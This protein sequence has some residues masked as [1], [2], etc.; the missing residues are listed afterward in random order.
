MNPTHEGRDPLPD[1]DQAQA[2]L[3]QVRARATYDPRSRGDATPTW[4][5]YLLGPGWQVRQVPGVED[6]EPQ[7]LA[8]GLA[9]LGYALS[10]PTVLPPVPDRP[11]EH[12][13]AELV[14]LPATALDCPPW[15]TS[16][17]QAGTGPDLRHD[18][19]SGHAYLT[20]RTGLGAAAGTRVAL[21]RQVLLAP[22][23]VHGRTGVELSTDENGPPGLLTGDQ[24]AA[25]ADLLALA[26]RLTHDDDHQAGPQHGPHDP[27]ER[28]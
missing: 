6:A 7:A 26:A 13:T 22:A 3:H 5:T 27:Q 11:G 1:D 14:P 25:L 20:H 10:A 24:A 17:T 18:P 28:A 23:P 19:A 21:G 9:R 15:C 8:L 16:C 2:R 4:Q 12:V